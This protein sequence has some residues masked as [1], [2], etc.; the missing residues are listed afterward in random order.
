VGFKDRAEGSESKLR[1]YHDGLRIARMI[2]RLLHHERPLALYSTIAALTVLTAVGVAIPVIQEFLETGLVGRFPTAFGAA[3]LVVVAFI[4]LVVGILLE[5]LRKVRQETTRI[6]YMKTPAI[7]RV[8]RRPVVV[9]LAEAERDALP[10]QETRTWS[11]EGRAR[12]EE[13]AAESLSES[14]SEHV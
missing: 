1:T 9:A 10:T 3:S 7:P 6:A 13:P 11:Y 12:P 5:G 14:A 8:A 2:T 4:V